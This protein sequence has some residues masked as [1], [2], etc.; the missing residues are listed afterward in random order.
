MFFKKNSVILKSLV[1]CIR[2]VFSNDL[3]II[4]QII[5]I[6]YENDKDLIS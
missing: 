4:V 5:P 2:D 1:F 6:L 3:Q